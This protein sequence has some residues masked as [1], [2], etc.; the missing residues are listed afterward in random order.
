MKPLRTPSS[1]GPR[2]LLFSANSTKALETSVASY[3]DFIEKN[4]SCIPDLAYTLANRREHLV[5]RAFSIIDQG[6]MGATSIPTKSVRASELVMVF[7]GQGAQWSQMGL[8]LLDSDPTFLDSIRQL[9]GYLQCVFDEVPQWT[10]EGQIRQ[11]GNKGRLDAAEL[12]QP[13]TTAIQVALVDALA[14]KGVCPVAVVGH[15]SGEIAGAYAAGAITAKEAILIALYRGAAAT[16][17]SK[18][19]A[20]AAIGLS[21][22]E[23]EKYLVTNVG[24]ACDN[25]PNS[26]TIS[27][28][29]DAVEAVITRIRTSG[30]NVLARKLQV[31]KAYHS[32]HM[33][34]VGDHYHSLLVDCVREKRPTKLF[35]SSVTGGP[36]DFGLGPKYWQNNMESPV[37]FKSAVSHVLRH[38]IGANA[39]FLEVGPHSALAGPLRQVLAHEGSKASYVSTMTRYRNCS[40]TFISALGSLWSLQ[41]PLALEV[42]FPSGSCLTDLPPYPW[43]HEESYWYESRLSKEFRHRKYSHCD[44]LGSRVLESTDLEPAWRNVF[45]LDNTPWIRDHK[46]ESDVVFPFA[47]YIAMAGEA[48]RQIDGTNA[49]G[50]RLRRILVSTA[51]I[52]SDDKTTE[53]ITTLRRQRLTDTLDS[54]WWEFSISSHNGRAWIQHCTGEAAIYSDHLT[55]RQPPQTFTKKIIMRKW[56]H[57]L[58]R[59]GLDL[60]P[61]FQRLEDVSAAT[62]AQQARG[63]VRNKN[64]D[65]DRYHL[66]PTAV[67]AALQLVGVAFARG[68]PRK[69]KTRLPTTCDEI[70]ISRTP[71]DF[72]VEAAAKVHGSTVVGDI[73]GFADGKTILRI[74]GLKLASIDSGDVSVTENTHAAARQTW[75]PDVDFMNTDLM[76]KLT[77]PFPTLDLA[78]EE[79]T[80]LCLLQIQNQLAETPPGSGNGLGF[81]RFIDQEVQL[82]DTTRFKASTYDSRVERLDSLVQGLASTEASSVAHVLKSITQNLTNP[83][84]PLRSWRKEVPSEIIESFHQFI[85]RYDVSRFLQIVAHSKPN[86]RVLEISSWT[87]S[88][89]ESV[90]K[91]L[92]LADGHLMCSKYTFMTRNYISPAQKESSR[93]YLEYITFNLDE[94]P[95]DHGFGQYDLIITNYSV[96][97]N[98]DTQSTLINVRKLLNPQGHLLLRE[99]CAAP[100]WMT[101]VFGTNPHWWSQ[102]SH[103]DF[104][105]SRG[106]PVKWNRELLA[107]GFEGMDLSALD[108]AGYTCGVDRPMILRPV[109][110]PHRPKQVTLLR[111]DR[112]DSPLV[113]ALNKRGYEITQCTLQDCLQPSSDVIALLDEDGPF[114][115]TLNGQSYEAFQKIFKMLGNAGVLWITRP[116]QMN[117]Q[118]PRFAQVIGA[119][120]TIRSELLVDFATC[121]VD[122]LDSSLDQIILVF[123]K[124]QNRKT[125]DVLR[126]EFEYAIHDGTVYINRFFP[127][128]LPD[129]LLI[130]EPGDRAMLDIAVAGRLGSLHWVRRAAIAELKPDEVEI[131]IHAVGLN[132]RVR[133]IAYGTGPVV[134]NTHIRAGHPDSFANSRARRTPIWL[135]RSRYS[136]ADG[137]GG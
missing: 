25:S 74:S 35:F 54:Q 128:C 68:E 6:I 19:G 126:P 28:D 51:L 112:H 132:F 75:G 119:A 13:L 47:G 71:I 118:D 81:R 64:F 30:T 85:D 20:M 96:Y 15:S 45:H 24:I 55:S 108:A 4:P 14:S 89:S 84:G 113:Q 38:R 60:G 130:A 123:E 46:V 115:E 16:T 88:P 49:D 102:E 65:T 80:D 107:A 18:P 31:D 26:V 2:L 36:V 122:S 7:T 125:D 87:D 59:A 3:Q 37:L 9:D 86:L 104:W 73:R 22:R 106:N 131:E 43:D 90:L 110:Q 77:R 135:R 103:G 92:T 42:L 98:A 72:A 57:T 40:E 27:G 21:W 56:F 94:D 136:P 101:F 117:C 29:T 100:R 39:V 134:A 121:E 66:H 61:A 120:R 70:H 1:L 97:D 95:S 105:E 50:F 67:D 124:F 83:C 23:T 127:F 58:Q 78:L 41:V 111:G 5:Y 10:L 129:E 62:T 93:P 114:F 11:P 48:I 137:F 76:I 8:E 82:I 53:T 99:P 34:D 52:L 33:A 91:S 79:L 109:S 133:T 69:H 63:T 12:A 44:L 116:C 17:Q 32:H